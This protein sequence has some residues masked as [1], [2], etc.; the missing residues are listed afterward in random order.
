MLSLALRHGARCIR[1][2]AMVRTVVRPDG[3]ALLLGGRRP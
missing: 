3:M 1:K 2:S